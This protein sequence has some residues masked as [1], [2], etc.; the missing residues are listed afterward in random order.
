MAQL[1]ALGLDDAKI[2]QALSLNEGDVAVARLQIA[3]DTSA[4]F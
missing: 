3:A 4:G 1:V 2:A